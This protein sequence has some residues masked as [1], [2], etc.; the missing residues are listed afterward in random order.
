MCYDNKVSYT[1]VGDLQ[2]FMFKVESEDKN[3]HKLSRREWIIAIVSAII[4][5]KLEMFLIYVK[6]IIVFQ[7][8]NGGKCF[9][10]LIIFQ[11]MN[12]L[13]SFHDLCVNKYGGICDLVV[14]LMSGKLE[15][16]EI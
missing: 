14:R 2:V 6:F 15:V 9:V 1:L 3:A 8:I 4:G 10:E 16:K 11:K 12:L 5:L 13:K 7:K